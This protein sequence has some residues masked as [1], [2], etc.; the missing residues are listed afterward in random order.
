MYLLIADCE[1]ALCLLVRLRIAIE[2]LDGLVV[3][4]YRLCKLDVTLCVLMARVYFGVVWQCR[5]C[6]VQRF[7][8]L[9]CR[10]L[11]E[12]ATAADEHGVAGKDS[13]VISIF[14]VEANAVLCVAW[15][16]KGGDFDRT[17]V[18]RLLVCRGLVDQSAVAAANDGELVVFELIM[19]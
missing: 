5:Q 15:C 9:L 8:H 17:D 6:L 11:K 12:A 1:F 16:V 2:L 13:F 7:V 18:E 3:S 10:A 4:R 19:S 14:E